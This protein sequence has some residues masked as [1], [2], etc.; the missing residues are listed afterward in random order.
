M[1][2]RWSWAAAPGDGTRLFY[3]DDDDHGDGRSPVVLC[4]GIGCDGYVWRY[5]RHSLA[6]RRVLHP[7]YRG[8]GRSQTPRDLARVSIPDLADD[9]AAVLD[10]A[11]ASR[12]I[13][14]GHSM[15]VQVALE[16]WRRYPER[17]A[18]L[19]LV[20]GAPSHPLRTFRGV[21]TLEDLLPTIERLIV[22]APRLINGFS[23]AL[24]PTKLA[25][26]IAGRV[27]INRALVQPDDFMPYLQG[28]AR[29]DVRVFLA[30]LAAAGRHS[31]E[32]W[33]GDIDIPTLVV[34]GGRDGFTPP[35]RSREMAAAIPGATLFEVPDGSHT[36]PIE[37]PAE[38]DAAIVSFSS[39]IQ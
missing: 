37:R 28:M 4:D 21:R 13:L 18:G 23:R 29:M 1:A 9:L 25:L 15:G 8:H 32:E 39:E 34:A 30:M 17:V 12:A 6:P 5:L 24:L 11:G 27:E 7:H 19:V 2:T 36:A 35:E 16:T 22:R 14:V 38:I 31:S 3:S 26:A 33:L 20:C 10:D